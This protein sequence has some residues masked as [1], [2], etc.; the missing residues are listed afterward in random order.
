MRYSISIPPTSPCCSKPYLPSPRLSPSSQR[1]RPLL[2]L[3]HLAMLL[4]VDLRNLLRPVKTRVP[5]A[6][7]DPVTLPLVLVLDLELAL[8]PMPMA[9]R[10]ARS[11]R[12]THWRV[13]PLSS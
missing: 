12:A 8:S 2:R 1:H 11:E 4:R 6:M 10:Y 3:S 13:R 5:V 7:R 9:T